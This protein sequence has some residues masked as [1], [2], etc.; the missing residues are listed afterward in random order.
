[1]AI[2]KA[3]TKGTAVKKPA[4]KVARFNPTTTLNI[5]KTTLIGDCIDEVANIDREIDKLMAG[6]SALKKVRE[7]KVTLLLEAY[8]A[9]HI[10][11]SKGSL[12]TAY[13]S[14]T[15]LATVK[16]WASVE[17][18]VYKHKAFDLFQRRIMNS[19]YF[20]RI[21]AGENIAGVDVYERVDLRFKANKE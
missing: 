4:G 20:D 6:V 10:T 12:A 8:A 17:A 2:S 7:E 1:M 19:A 13:V 18:Y 11:S 9:E 5:T 15:K 16:D 21:A 3:K 14:K